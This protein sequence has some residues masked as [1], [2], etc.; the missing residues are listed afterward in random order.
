M[1]IS[2]VFI[3]H[4]L[5]GKDKSVWFPSPDRSGDIINPFHATGLSIPPE[6]IRKPGFLMF[7]GGL[8]RVSGMKWIKT[9]EVQLQTCL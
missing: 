9:I 2:R 5:G 1:L 6:N 4:E 7:S 8:E 3:N